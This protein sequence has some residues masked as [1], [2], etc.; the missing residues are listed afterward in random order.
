M[1]QRFKLTLY[2][3]VYDTLIAKDFEQAKRIARDTEAKYRVVTREGN[4]IDHS[5]MI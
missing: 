1:D 4:L 3:G 2:S 5:G